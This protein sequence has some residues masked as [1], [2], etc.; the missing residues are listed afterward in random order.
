MRESI[1]FWPA[2]CQ[3]RPPLVGRFVHDSLNIYNYDD[4]YAETL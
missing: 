3:E 4:L 2:L 1:S